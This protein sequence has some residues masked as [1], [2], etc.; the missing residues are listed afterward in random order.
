MAKGRKDGTFP[1]ILK[2]RGAELSPFLVSE[3][4]C[5]AWAQPSLPSW[6]PARRRDRDRDR[7][8]ACAPAAGA[9]GGR[10][11]SAPPEVFQAGDPSLPQVRDPGV[12]VRV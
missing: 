10:I 3:T 6:N 7:G 1:G 4:A 12:P 2:S 11:D 5:Q 9:G 8:E